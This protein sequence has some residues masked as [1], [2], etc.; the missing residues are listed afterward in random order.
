M[1]LKTPLVSLSRLS[2]L[3]LVFSCLSSLG[4]AANP[5]TPAKKEAV[6]TLKA[7]LQ[8]TDLSWTGRKVTGEH[9]GA[10]KLKAG[11]LALQGDAITGGKFEIDMTSIKVIDVTDPK[12]N[13]KL[14]NH[15]KSDDFFSV[16]KNPTATFELASA[17]AVSGKPGVTHELSGTLTIKGISQSITFPASIEKKAGQLTMTAKIMVDR[18][19]YNVRYGSGKFFEN[20]GNKMINDEFQIDLKLVAKK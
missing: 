2:F 11:S 10:V 15:L 1:N 20:L 19:K 3:V 4:F 6:E 13:A 12:D 14:T 17:K 7:D 5:A 16:E 8:S 9:H 18:T